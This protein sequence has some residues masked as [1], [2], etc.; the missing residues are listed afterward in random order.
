MDISTSNNNVT[1]TG[2]IKTMTDFQIIK[3]SIDAIASKN[4]E[5]II[6][7]KDSISIT[8]SVIGYFNKLALKDHKKITINAGNDQLIALIKDLNLDSMLT[9]KKV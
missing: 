1:I 5:I 4:T 8:S 6:N 9:T 2:N 3:S 7:I